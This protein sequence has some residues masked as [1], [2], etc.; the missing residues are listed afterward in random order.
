MRAITMSEM[1]MGEV[2]KNNV[3]GSVGVGVYCG[4]HSMCDVNQNVVVGTR[5]DNT[6][7]EA[8]AGV[9]IE[10]NFYAEADLDRNVLIGNPKPVAVF[11]QSR[12]VGDE[13]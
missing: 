2:T 7:N 10:A 6:G 13:E 3:S 12:L 5:S 11:D 9:G 1:S 8:A 4:D